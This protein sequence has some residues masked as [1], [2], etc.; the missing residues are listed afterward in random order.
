MERAPARPAR[1]ERR[2]AE[3]H[4]RQAEEVPF[5]KLEFVK[6][7]STGTDSVAVTLLQ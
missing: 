1:R 7:F 5:H 6:D 2:Q 3:P 4:V